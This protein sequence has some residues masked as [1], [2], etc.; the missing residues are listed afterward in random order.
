MEQNRFSLGHDTFATTLGLFEKRLEGDDALMQ[1]ARLRFQQAGLGAEMHADAPETLEPLLRF[2]PSEQ[3]AVVVHLPRHFS[4]RQESTGSRIVQFASR[5]S[6]RINGLVLHDEAEMGRRPG[7]FRRA[8]QNLDS[9]L[10][11]FDRCPTVFLE[12]AAGLAPEAFCEFFSSIRE[13]SR[14]SA[15]VDV[16]HV[17][18]RQLRAA[19]A[20]AHPGEDL[21]AMK[22]QPAKQQAA[23]AAVD[24]AV[25]TALPGVLE[26]ID[27]LGTIGKP[28]HFHLHDGHPFSRFSPFGVSDHLSFLAEIP[29]AFEHLGRRFLLPMFGPAGLKKIVAEAVHAIGSGRVS[30]TLEIHPT[31]GRLA[32]DDAAAPLFLH[33]RDKTNAEKMNHWLSVLTRNQALV[34]SAINQALA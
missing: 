11:P 15:C 6:G 7:D 3:A 10:Q 16:G 9:L 22:T 29:V 17:G 26:V 32:L 18:I 13:L 14:I 5:F 19:F 25:A 20:A 23:I 21:C 30:F 8:A 28:I 12:Y 33:W 31:D 24:S 34:L 1:L 4:L 27:H 2:R